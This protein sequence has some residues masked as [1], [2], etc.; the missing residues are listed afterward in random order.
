MSQQQ[1]SSSSDSWLGSL[2]LLFQNPYI[3]YGVIASGLAASY[4]GVKTASHAYM[5]YSEE[6]S[7]KEKKQKIRF[8]LDKLREKHSNTS[9]NN[10]TLINGE[11]VF[12]DELLDTVNAIFYPTFGMSDQVPDG[13]ANHI[14]MV[15]SALYQ[16]KQSEH[17]SQPPITMDVYLKNVEMDAQRLELSDTYLPHSD[18]AEILT[19]WERDKLQPLLSKINVN[20]LGPELGVTVSKFIAISL[21]QLFDSIFTG[22]TSTNRPDHLIYHRL[23]QH[24]VLLHAIKV[25]CQ[26]NSTDQTLVIQTSTTNPTAPTLTLSKHLS[27]QVFESVLSDPMIIELLCG[28]SGGAFHPAIMLSY[29]VLQNFHT[30]TILTALGYFMY[31]YHSLAPN[32]TVL[33]EYLTVNQQEEALGEEDEIISKRHKFSTMKE[34]FGKIEELYPEYFTKRFRTERFKRVNFLIHNLMNS[35]KDGL[36]PRH[37]AKVCSFFYMINEKKSI[38]PRFSLEDFEKMAL[39][40]YLTGPVKFDIVTLHCITG[41]FAVRLLLP[42]IHDQNVQEKI[43]YHLWESFVCVYLLI[44]GS[45]HMRNDLSLSGVKGDAVED[46]HVPEWKEILPQLQ[47]NFDEHDIKLVY[48]AFE[49]AKIHPKW[50]IEYRKSAAKRVGLLKVIESDP[51]SKP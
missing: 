41:C 12:V 28:L 19:N 26:E 22:K 6:R 43:L 14:P 33:R 1:P 36:R 50:E 30:S 2:A 18:Q 29:G 24:L 32:E 46:R 7:K 9:N 21:R 11:D 48:T 39:E 23:M 10:K 37:Y 38:V 31:A 20:T 13:L 44:G 3:K 4:F 17:V 25:K 15:L 35:L 5:D 47:D 27:Q 42:Y 16:L 34:L 51:E 49:E 45:S 8:L 40:M